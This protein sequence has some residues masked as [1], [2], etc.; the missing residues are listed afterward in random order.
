MTYGLIWASV[1]ELAWPNWSRETNPVHVPGAAHNLPEVHPARQRPLARP[2]KVRKLGQLQ[3]FIA[4]FPAGIHGPTYMSQPNSNTLCLLQQLRVLR[5]RRPQADGGAALHPGRRGLGRAGG[6]AG[7]AYRAAG[8][9]RRAAA[10]ACG[11]RR[12]E[13]PVR[14]VVP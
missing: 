4:V 9:T 2:R 3:P 14:P 10:R 12:G 11:G 6:G 1:L 8:R 13:P 7:G 5:P